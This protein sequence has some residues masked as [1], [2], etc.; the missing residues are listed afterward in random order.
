MVHVHPANIYLL[1]VNNRNIRKRSETCSKLTIKTP[2]R[3]PWRRFG[4]FIVKFK[5]NITPF[6]CISIVDFDQV[7][8]SKLR[9]VQ[10]PTF[11]YSNPANVVQI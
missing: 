11:P 5:H 6:S 10:H 4:V 1:K 9:T 7:N 2:E 3:R 8:V